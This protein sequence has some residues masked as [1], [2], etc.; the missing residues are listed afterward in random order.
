M[1]KKLQKFF[2]R[3]EDKIRKSLSASP[4]VYAL[5]AGTAV[6]L[7]WRGIWE[8]SDLIGLHPIASLI[9]GTLVLL[10][11]GVFVSAFIGNKI[12]ISGLR[13]E[14][15]I[16]EKTI[17]EIESEEETLNKIYRKLEKIDEEVLEIK[18]KKK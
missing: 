4:L 11:S 15:K 16:E 9:I 13:G 17:E 6:V 5:I 10:L 7:F 8:T 1:I 14:K 3:L 18:E 12:I 2:D